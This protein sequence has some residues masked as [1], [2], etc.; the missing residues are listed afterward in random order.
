MREAKKV[1][2]TDYVWPDLEPEKAIFDPL[3][4]ELIISP[5]SSEDTLAELAKDADG[6]LTC[7]AQ[8]TPRV[9]AGAERMK[10]V[11]RYGVGTD[12]IAVADA[13]SLGIAVT[14]V[15][16]YCVD[17]VSDHVLA[18]L[19]SF[20]RRVV[21][22]DNATKRDGWGSVELN[23]PM[24]RLRGLTIGVVGFGRIGRAA[25][26]KAE[27]FGLKVLVADPFV[28]TALVQ[29]AGVKL[30]ELPT[31]LA[32]S[33]FVTLHSPLNEDTTGM[34]GKAELETM[35]DSAFLI[36]CARGPLIDEPSLVAALNGGEI[37]GAGLDVMESNHPESDHPL[38]GMDN[39]I[40]SPHVAFYSPESTRELQRRA[41][42]SVAEVLGGHMPQNL[43][44]REVIGKA[45]A[46]LASE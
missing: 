1:L 37:A 44:N 29:E 39:V 9:L 45:R 5:D 42:E 6:I 24:T 32:A 22:F 15:P 18:F 41:T 4:I 20:N 17:E 19:L 33:D 10:V 43:Y 25:A 16:D 7:F 11:A 8:V 38:F 13:T 31:L 3:G 26:R 36:N 30:V 34:I 23:L 27:A 14:Y 40:V 28:D 2:I 35:K 12:N 46:A 21:V